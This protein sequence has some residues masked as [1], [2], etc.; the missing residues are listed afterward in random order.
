MPE[1]P[2]VETVVRMLSPL[3]GRTIREVRV[4]HRPSIA[5]SPAKFATIHGRRIERVHRRAKFIR[6]DL[7]DGLGI[8][9]HLRMTGWL[10]VVPANVSIPK[11]DAYVRVRFVLDDGREHLIFS[12]IRTFGRVWC[13][14][15]TELSALKA[16]AKLG[17]EPLTLAPR[18]FAA[19]LRAR[20]GRLK[21]LLLNQE[22][23]AGI[24]NIYADESLFGAGLHPLANSARI[25]FARAEL[26]LAS[27]QKVLQ[28]AIDA[29][30]SS[31]E[32]FRRPD[33]ES[34]WFQR[35][36][37]V[38]G[39]AGEPCVVCGAAVKRIVVGQ[40]GTWFCGKC[41]KRS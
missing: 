8:V 35:Q 7:D 19:M 6:M 39:R 20:K 15:S 32:N 5:G 31:V 30:G 40:R 37:R 24:G 2:E 23:I 21:A 29:G 11:L 12:D 25:T 38:Y 1:L 33:G 18:D 9:T 4:L 36:L 28:A 22:F 17:P 26:L 10:G 13:G 16:L 34:G 3:R 27:I 41:Q 14:S